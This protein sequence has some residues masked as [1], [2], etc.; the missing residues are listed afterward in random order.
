MS[1]FYF[2]FFQGLSKDEFD[3]FM[4][5]VPTHLKQKFQK[6]ADNFSQFDQNKDNIIDSDEFGAMLDQVME[7]EGMQKH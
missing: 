3:R 2:L 7:S 4:K 5:R 6:I 1:I